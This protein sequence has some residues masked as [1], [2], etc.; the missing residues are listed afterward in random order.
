MSHR[1]LR[2]LLAISVGVNV[3][4][5][6]AV[7]VHVYRQGGVPYVLLKLGLRKYEAKRDAWQVDL[8]AEHRALPAGPGDVVFFG[9]SLVYMTPFADVFTPVKNRGVGRETT[10]GA[11]A[12]VDDVLRGRPERLVVLLGT[13]DVA[14][15]LP[16]SE[17]IG[18]YRHILRAAKA[19]S[20]ETR[21]YVVSV[22]PVNNDV[23]KE[24]LDRNPPIDALNAELVALTAEEGAAFVDVRPAVRD[25]H[26]R[27]RADYTTDGIHLT[28]A[29]KLALCEALRPAVV[30]GRNAVAR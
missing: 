18:N 7:G 23:M 1:T 29:G 4:V 9:D 6:G 27:L 24:P 13:N 20:P 28:T 26:G 11:L 25:D 30:D 21:V 8:L 22:L 19:R 14:R 17:I 12:R 2:T 15:Q 16:G 10:A 5:A 3:L